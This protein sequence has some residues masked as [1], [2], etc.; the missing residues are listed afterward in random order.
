M[1][2]ADTNILFHAFHLR[3]PWH[4]AARAFLQDH[5]EDNDFAVCELVLVEF[6]GL[7]RNPAVVEKPLSPEH[8]VEVCQVYR[9]NRHWR[10]IDYPGGL[11]SEVWQRAASPNFARRRIYEVRL[12]LTLRHH[13]VTELATR[14]T[15]DF[16]D[17][18]FA[19][20]WDPLEQ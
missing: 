18:G 8:A 19:R 12:A 11:M 1:L 6:Y 10:V 7:I 9:R 14:N 13:G 4:A 16:Q 3:S 2:S 20:V 5:A 17:F 15:K